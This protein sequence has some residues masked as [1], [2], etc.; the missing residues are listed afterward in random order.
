MGD[1][2]N[3]NK[4]LNT[5]LRIIK[6]KYG[7]EMMHL[8]RKLFPTLLEEPGL[9]S[10]Q[11]LN[12]F[13]PTRFLYEDIV[14]NNL[15][16]EFKDYVY[17][18]IPKEDKE[19]IIT[20]KTPKQLM[21]IAGYNLYECKSEFHIKLFTRYYQLDEMLCTFRERRTKDHYVFFAV[22]KNVNQIKRKDFLLPKREDEY[23][24]SVIS[25]QF[26][27]GTTNTL[28]IKNRYNHKV[29]NCDSTFSNNLDNIIYGLKDSFEKYYNLNLENYNSDLNIPGYIKA[30]D[31]KFYKYNYE[32]NNKYYCPNNIIIDNGKVIKTYQENEKYIILDYFILDLV[33]K[34]IYLYD[35]SIN[36]S[37]INTIKDI[38]K[39]TIIKSKENENKTIGIICENNKIIIEL[40]KYNKIIGYENQNITKIEDNFLNKNTVL[41]YINLPNVKEIGKFFLTYN[42]NI[43]SIS[44]PNLIDI[45]NHFLT[46]NKKINI[47]NIPNIINIGNSFLSNNIE[48][49]E[50]ILPTLITIG[51]RALIYNRKI[52]KIDLNNLQR[53]GYTFHNTDNG[54]L[55]EINIPY[56]EN[57]IKKQLETLVEKNKTKE[58]KQLLNMKNNKIL[59]RTIA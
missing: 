44:F 55:T 15:I 2:I 48:L 45:G 21:S 5:D 53:M 59:R 18:S 37:F 39:I 1:N 26:R 43:T 27:K 56:I 28:S 10:K 31:G 41:Q 12:L 30:D 9:L 23:G 16:E 20:D 14:S 47:L 29:L 6:K 35:N 52:K 46:Y 13:E 19:K 32:Y 3:N 58:L 17:S 8:C 25:L 36:D 57:Y 11:I 24:T 40:D 54:E 38:K 22:K 7:E 34:Q 50:L 33:N 42:Q 4:Q 51:D 49:N